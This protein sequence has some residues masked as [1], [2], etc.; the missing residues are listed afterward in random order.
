MKMAKWTHMK[1]KLPNGEIIDWD[2]FD[3][4]THHYESTIEFA[5]KELNGKGWIKRCY[6]HNAKIAA[7]LLIKHFGVKGTR[8][9]AIRWSKKN[10]S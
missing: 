3:C 2:V 5:E 8:S 1:S 6:D 9:R 7:K 10:F 4:S